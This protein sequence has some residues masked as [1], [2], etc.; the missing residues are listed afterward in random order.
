MR[1]RQ[2]GILNDIFGRILESNLGR[3]RPIS[4]MWAIV[5]GP[6]DRKRLENP[7]IAGGSRSNEAGNLFTE[8]RSM[9]LVKRKCVHCPQPPAEGYAKAGKWHSVPWTECLKCPL[10]VLP[11]R[12]RFHRCS[13]KS[14]TGEEAIGKSLVEVSSLVSKAVATANEV[15]G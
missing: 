8:D 6:W 9:V 14:S 2:S 12:I 11:G 1:R 5:G 4:N 10:H 15:M 3:L 13:F 7:N